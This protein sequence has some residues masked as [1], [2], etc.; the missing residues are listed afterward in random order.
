LDKIRDDFV[1]VTGDI[2][3]NIVFLLSFILKIG[4]SSTYSKTQVKKQILNVEEKKEK[5]IQIF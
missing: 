2:I 1:L 4:F 3:T 5:K